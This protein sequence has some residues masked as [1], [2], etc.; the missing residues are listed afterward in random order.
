MLSDKVFRLHADPRRANAEYLT[1]AMNS[2]A[3]RAQIESVL[4]GSVG[5]ARNI[6]Q[7]TIREL[8][9]C[10]PPLDEQRTIVRDLEAD[11][12]PTRILVGKVVQ[13][14]ERLREYRSAL[15]TSAVTGQIDVREYAKEAN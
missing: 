5:L 9:V 14:I 1:L 2:R 6:G 4:S 8:A 11:A 10:F 13:A 3:V 15:I 12:G 7:S